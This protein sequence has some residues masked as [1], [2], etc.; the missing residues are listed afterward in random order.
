MLLIAFKWN[1]RE[2][3]KEYLNP[4]ELGEVCEMLSKEREGSPSFRLKAPH[5]YTRYKSYFSK[6]KNRL[7][8]ATTPCCKL[9]QQVFSFLSLLPI[10]GRFLF[11]AIRRSFA[12]GEG[13][14]AAKAATAAAAAVR[15]SFGLVINVFSVL[16]TVCLLYCLFCVIL[17]T[18]FVD[19]LL[20]LVIAG[21]VGISLLHSSSCRGH[22]AF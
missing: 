11:F 5:I 16:V 9:K 1:S 8:S 18:C 4:P 20:L 21:V 19:A 12:C 17:A 22:R 2:L 14:L 10:R 3:S 6:I 7:G 13:A 15:C